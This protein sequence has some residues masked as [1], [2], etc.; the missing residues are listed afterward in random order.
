MK[1]LLNIW[2][3]YEGLSLPAFSSN[4]NMAAAVVVEISALPFMS[5][6]RSPSPAVILSFECRSTSPGLSSTWYTTFVLPSVTLSPTLVP[7]TPYSYTSLFLHTEKSVKLKYI[8]IYCITYYIKKNKDKTLRLLF[9][10]THLW[11]MFVLYFLFWEII[12]IVLCLTMIV[13]YL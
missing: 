2:V 1:I 10:S 6:A 5:W 12:P 4:S 3:T 11:K 8:Q 7:K 9:D 13:L